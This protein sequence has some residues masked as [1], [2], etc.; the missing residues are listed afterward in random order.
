MESSN[1]ALANLK[2]FFTNYVHSFL[3]E[4]PEINLA[5]GVA[6]FEVHSFSF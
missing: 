2:M 1:Y 3:S 4:K 6:G 5:T